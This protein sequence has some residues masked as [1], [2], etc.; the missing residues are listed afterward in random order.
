MEE[1][2]AIVQGYPR[3]PEVELVGPRAWQS[4]PEVLVDPGRLKQVLLN[5]LSNAL[6][7]TKEGSVQVRRGAGLRQVSIAVADTGIGVSQGSPGATCSRSSSRPRVGTPG[8]TAA[9]AWA[10]S[11]ASTSWR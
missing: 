4:V 1:V 5:L 10:W 9:P 8:S 6:K 2:K 7:F 11:S 3:K